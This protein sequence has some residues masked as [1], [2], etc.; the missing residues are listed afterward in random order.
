M[1]TLFQL[2]LY[3]FTMHI[4]SYQSSSY[5][6]FLINYVNVTKYWVFGN[7]TEGT[8][9]QKY[10]LHGYSEGVWDGESMVKWLEDSKYSYGWSSAGGTEA[11]FLCVPD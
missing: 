3:I 2:A 1:Y 8:R 10:D 11:V 7:D 6:L 4:I 9:G 5:A